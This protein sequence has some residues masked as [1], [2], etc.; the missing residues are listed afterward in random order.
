M[1]Q[2]QT[3]QT[4]RMGALKASYAELSESQ[5]KILT[6]A[7]KIFIELGKPVALVEGDVTNIKLTTIM[8]YKVAQAMLQSGA[9]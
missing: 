1:Y 8:D 4:F 6:D 7:C 5:K 2:G 3:P 9:E